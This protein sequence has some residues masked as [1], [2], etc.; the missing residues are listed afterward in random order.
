MN[1]SVRSISLTYGDAQFSF[2]NVQIPPSSAD[3]A[4]TQ[5]GHAF[6]EIHMVKSGPLV[7]HLSDTTLTVNTG[8]SLIIPPHTLHGTLAD[9]GDR[10]SVAF[11]LKKLDH[12]ER[13]YDLFKRALDGCRLTPFA[14]ADHQNGDLLMQQDLYRSFAGKLQLQSAAAA[15]VWRLFTRLIG[16]ADASTDADKDILLVLD[17]FIYRYH[18]TLDEIA[19][20]TNYSKRH[21]SRLIKQHYG[22][23]LSKLRKQNRKEMPEE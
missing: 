9:S 21:I 20:A 18:S 19:A 2:W 17:E 23:S 5:H 6:Y 11:S 13:Y 22:T 3:D 16:N 10:C 15:F 4:P 1:S 8:E 14:F 12:G 7:Y